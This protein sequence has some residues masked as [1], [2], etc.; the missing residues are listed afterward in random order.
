MEPPS[1]C[2]RS[3]GRSG[4]RCS[5]RARGLLVPQGRGVEGASTSATTSTSG[6]AFTVCAVPPRVG[7]ADPALTGDG[8]E[9]E[10]AH[11]WITTGAECR[12]GW[13]WSGGAVL[14]S[15]SLHV[16]VVPCGVTGSALE[17]DA[18]SGVSAGRPVL[19]HGRCP[20]RREGELPSPA[21]DG[22]WGDADAVGYL[23][24][25]H[26]H[27]DEQSEVSWDA[28]SHSPSLPNVMDGW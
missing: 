10:S 24:V 11:P 25:A 12:A 16:G 5:R 1:L 15:A 7:G 17:A 23:G 20:A 9:G 18:P 21:Q 8:T 22:S 6:P 14:L 2:R 3:V 27:I 19:W 13:G 28:V 26:A 4:R